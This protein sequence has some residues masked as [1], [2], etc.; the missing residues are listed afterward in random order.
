M[1]QTSIGLLTAAFWLA[2]GPLSAQTRAPQ[3]EFRDLLAKQRRETMQEHIA[4]F[5]VLLSRSLEKTYGFPFQVP[6]H[7]HG[8]GGG[9]FAGGGG[10][11]G[12]GSGGFAGG[13]GFSGGG[14]SGKSER[15]A[16]HQL[17]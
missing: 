7:P 5:R 13:G 3:E 17:P 15:D 6:G 9:G 4:V 12:G 11:I 2:A 1:K 16:I 8:M 14:G 10:G